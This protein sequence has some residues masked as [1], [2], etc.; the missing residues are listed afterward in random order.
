MSG[1]EIINKPFFKSSVIIYVAPQI[2]INGLVVE[3]LSQKVTIFDES[4]DLSK[5]EA[6]LM[7]K[8]LHTEGFI[9]GDRVLLEIVTDYDI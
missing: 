4:G 2:T 3:I 6:L 8:Y 1:S 9:L 7:L 5:K